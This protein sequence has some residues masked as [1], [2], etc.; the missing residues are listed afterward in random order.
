[1]Q[2]WAPHLRR[3]VDLLMWVQRKATKMFRGQVHL[4]CEGRLQELGLF[5]LEK[6]APGRPHHSFPVLRE[7]INRKK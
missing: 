5:I 7:L 4:F 2:A 6:R 3:D 1:V